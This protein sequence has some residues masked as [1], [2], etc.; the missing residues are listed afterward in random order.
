MRESLQGRSLPQPVSVLIPAAV[1]G[2]PD[3]GE[4]MVEKE[5]TVASEI[6][7]VLIVLVGLISQ[8]LR[9]LKGNGLGGF[10]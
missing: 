6:P 10:V 8:F 9:L 5:A 4:Q 2:Q 7:E 1:D 3:F